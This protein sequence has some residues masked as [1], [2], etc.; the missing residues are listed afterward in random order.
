MNMIQGDQQRH[1]Q[2]LARAYAALCTGTPPWVSLNE[3]FHEWFDYSSE[4]RE[5]LIADRIPLSPPPHSSKQQVECCP[6]SSV[7]HEDCADIT[8]PLVFADGCRRRARD[9]EMSCI[10]PVD[11]LR[12]AAFCAGVADY[13]CQ[14]YSVTRPTWPDDSQFTLTVPWYGFGDPGASQPEV[15]AHLERVTP[16][17][18]RRR[19]V[20]SGDRVFGSK[21]EFVDRVQQAYGERRRRPGNEVSPP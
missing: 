14:R 2:T 20:L 18:L 16:E 6:P 11:Q 7:G 1:V 3:F 21:Y 13:L 12:W 19:N 4:Q 15:R 5:R 17:V 9:G 8:A 10:D